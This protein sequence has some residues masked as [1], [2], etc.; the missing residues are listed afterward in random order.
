MLG[1]QPTG[2]ADA[3]LRQKG[4]SAGR[5]RVGN[6]AP[7]AAGDWEYGGAR[8]PGYRGREEGWG[9][10]QE[11]T[12]RRQRRAGETQ[13]NRAG[14]LGSW[15]ELL[16]LK[17]DVVAVCTQVPAGPAATPAPAAAAARGPSGRRP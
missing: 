10:V 5:A 14:F 13:H 12:G 11:A 17:L 4:G 16:L 9:V 6:G 1:S 2:V 15:S 3:G 8:W 7:I